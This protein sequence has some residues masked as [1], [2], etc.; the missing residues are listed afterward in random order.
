MAVSQISAVQFRKATTNSDAIRM[1]CI[2]YNEVLLSQA[3]ITAA[4]NVM[5]VVEARFCRWLLQS[6]D[7]AES[8]TLELTQE[9][10]AERSTHSGTIRSA[11]VG[12]VTPAVSKLS[13][14]IRGTVSDVS[15]CVTDSS[16]AGLRLTISVAGIHP[17][18]GSD[19][20]QG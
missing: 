19:Q 20:V 2:Q 15:A 4:C 8:D 11:S 3:R 14:S 13:E 7:R 6:A 16:K 17:L 1:M 5:H 12:V 9:F 18:A 10:L